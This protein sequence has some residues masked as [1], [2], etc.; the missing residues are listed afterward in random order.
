VDLHHGVDGV[1]NLFP[2]HARKA[3]EDAPHAPQQDE[4]SVELA[5]LFL[6]G[7]SE[8]DAKL[9]QFDVDCIAPLRAEERQ[10]EENWRNPSVGVQNGA[11][12]FISALSMSSFCKSGST[13]SASPSRRLAWIL[14]SAFWSLDIRTACAVWL[15]SSSATGPCFPRRQKRR[16]APA[17][18]LHDEIWTMAARYLGA[19][20]GGVAVA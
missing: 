9:R 3:G 7:I 4:H 2:G 20:P 18:L 19:R 11:H 1:V 15:A 13:R 5:L 8:F 10:K 14:S 6:A 17:H 12:T 16:W